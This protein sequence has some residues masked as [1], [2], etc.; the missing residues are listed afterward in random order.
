MK[1]RWLEDAVYDLQALRNYISVENPKAAAQVAKKILDG[2]H[3]MSE[4]PEIGRPGRVFNTREL[5]IT[6]TPYIIPY[7]VKDSIIE[8]IRVLHSARQWPGKF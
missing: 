8:I 6:K 3:I 7:R 5:V 4:Q 1:I 2:I